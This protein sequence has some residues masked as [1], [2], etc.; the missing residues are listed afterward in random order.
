MKDT[1]THHPRES[2]NKAQIL[3]GCATSC[4]CVRRS[5]WS[6]V[7]PRF[8]PLGPGVNPTGGTMWIGFSVPALTVWVIPW[9][10][11]LGVFLIKRGRFDKEDC[12]REGIKNSRLVLSIGSS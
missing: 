12:P 8:P 9:T 6:G 10:G 5:G 1:T 2:Y 4:P 3:S 7:L 11:S